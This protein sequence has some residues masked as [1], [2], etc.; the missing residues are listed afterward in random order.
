MRRKWILKNLKTNEVYQLDI[1]PKG[2]REMGL[3]RYRSEQYHGLFT[4][5]TVKT[6]T[7]LPNG[8]GA[9]WIETVLATDDINAEISIT[10]FR[11][12]TEADTFNLFFTG[13]LT[14][15]S[16]I[17]EERMLTF[18]IEQSNLYQKLLAR[19]NI[20]IDLATT[21]SIG[22]ETIYPINVETI[23]LPGQK[24]R[25][26]S[27]WR[28]PNGYSYTKGG[29]YSVQTNYQNH[30]YPDGDMIESDFKTTQPMVGLNYLGTGE[31][32]NFQELT[33]Q[34]FIV[35]LIDLMQPAVIYPLTLNYHIKY[36]GEVYDGE[37]AGGTRQVQFKLILFVGKKG[38]FCNTTEIWSSG[39]A[40]A[41]DPANF[42]FDI[43]AT[44]T[45]SLQPGEQIW[46]GWVENVTV[47]TLP[48]SASVN[49]AYEESSVSFYTDTEFTASETK[50]YLIHEAFNQVSDAIADK[51]TAFQSI[52]Y[53]RT[54]SGKISYDNDGEGSMLAIT[55]GDNIREK[56]GKG[57]FCNFKQLFNSANAVHNIGMEIANET[58]RVEPLSFFYSNERS[59]TL[60]YVKD[61]RSSLAVDRFI[62]H[63]TVGYANW[64]T[65]FANG[66]DEPNT[67]HEYSTVIQALNNKLELISD[68]IA[69]SYAIEVTRRK[70][71]KLFPKEDF[72]YDNNNFWLCV[73]RDG[74][75]FAAELLADAFVSASNMIAKDTALNLRMTPGRMLLAH[76]NKITAGLQTI[77]GDIKFING[78]GNTDFV[79]TK[80]DVGHQEDYNEEPLAE[81]T[82]FAW[83]DSDARDVLPIWMP[84]YDEF[85]FPLTEALRTQINNRPY[86]YIEF[87][88][89]SNERYKGYIESMEENL[90]NG[91]TKFKLL[92]KYGN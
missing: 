92:R 33:D 80:T 65:E 2:W 19:E 74:L 78:D 5:P 63:I 11:Q 79:S 76:I 52:F 8:G 7:F 47:L 85:E 38:E 89:Y 51:D 48:C 84:I 35:S 59:C 1:D 66:L 31:E 15:A 40:T 72:K 87:F 25:M 83:N 28:I 39:T 55:N 26:I 75:D 49:F 4:E 36:K 16:L 60:E 73:K 50:A 22:G 20:N 41:S 24:I 82:S 27:S 46:L 86:G 14:I 58:I 68:Y 69:S 18:T 54:D 67:R 34:G 6:L 71:V 81:N 13:V 61:I 43:D 53:G 23:P 17:R 62:N 91:L 30:F 64:E 42:S 9:E 57:V 32:Y 90:E 88:K 56:A 12:A 3:K 45:V 77:G 37:G 70:N 10:V 44:G 21:E 29:S